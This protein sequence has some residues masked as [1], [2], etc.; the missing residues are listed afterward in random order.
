MCIQ[1]PALATATPQSQLN[2]SDQST[3]AE[4]LAIQ[5]VYDP[6]KTV[7]ACLSRGSSSPYYQASSPTPQESRSLQGP[8][9][10][11]S[12]LFFLPL[13]VII[14]SKHSYI[15]PLRLP[16]PI[17]T[18]INRSQLTPSLHGNQFNTHGTPSECSS[19]GR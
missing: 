19:H 18:H 7:A 6:Q 1:S 8:T 13:C 17:I 10:H 12:P 4:S 5:T 9:R 3:A 11:P 15:T 16:P 2:S 14:V